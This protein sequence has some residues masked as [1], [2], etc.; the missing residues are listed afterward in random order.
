MSLE[1][2]L[3]VILFFILCPDFQLA[4]AQQTAPLPITSVTITA[5]GLSIID[6]TQQELH[7][8][9]WNSLEIRQ[10]LTLP[11]SHAHDVALSPDQTQLAVAGGNPGESAWVGLYVWPSLEPIWSREFSSDVA[12]AIAFHPNAPTMAVACHDS[13]VVVLDAR[14]S[15]TT[16]VLSGHSRPVTDV[17]LVPRDETPLLLSC[18]I[19]QTIRV[20]DVPASAVTRS[21]TNHTQSVTC[22]AVRPESGD[23]LA[24]VASGSEDKSVRFWQPGIGR[25]VRFKRL[26]S[27]VTAIAW[28]ID[29]SA[30]LAGGRD[31][32]VRIINAETLKTDEFSI[33]PHA[34]INAI[35]VHPAEPTAVVADSAGQLTKLNLER[36]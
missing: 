19:D 25:L 7:I 30:V 10:S 13:T 2:R 15:E 23:G 8:R 4:S 16:A 36:R 18:S 12:Y 9:D 32:T 22:L 31:G 20:W 17:T 28:T 3:C 1:R 6:T 21:L 27:P 35:A 24:I 14:T 33:A 5:D 11:C 29:G 34:W 26:D